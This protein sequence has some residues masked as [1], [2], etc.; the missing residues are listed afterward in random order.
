MQ[1]VN[2]HDNKQKVKHKSHQR[3]QTKA[4]SE[5]L[6]VFIKKTIQLELKNDSAVLPLAMGPEEVNHPPANNEIVPMQGTKHGVTM[7]IVIKK[8]QDKI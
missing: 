1:N 4:Q 6:Q 2:T 7:K 8:S 5:A 3:N